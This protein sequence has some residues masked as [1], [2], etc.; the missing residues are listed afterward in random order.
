MARLQ[1]ISRLLAS[2]RHARVTLGCVRAR[3]SA[4]LAIEP[5][6]ID[7]PGPSTFHR[8]PSLDEGKGKE[9]ERVS[10]S[11]AGSGLS[12]ERRTYFAGSAAAEEAD[13]VWG[14]SEVA[15]NVPGL[16]AGRVVECRR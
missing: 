12:S 6:Q 4:A 10:F 9:R 7:E 14:D 3:S 5:E 16:E 1:T 8:S 11:Q 2:S 15:Q 13:L